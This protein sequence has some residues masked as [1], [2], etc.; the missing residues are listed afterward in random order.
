MGLKK[1]R[2]KAEMKEHKKTIPDICKKH[3]ADVDVM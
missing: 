3:T 1:Y 2:N